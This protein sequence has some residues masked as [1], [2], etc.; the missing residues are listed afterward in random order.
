MGA[1]IIPIKVFAYSGFKGEEKPAYFTVKGDKVKVEE[2]LSEWLE[3]K[4]DE[5]GKRRHYFQ[6]K[7]KNGKRW[8]IF[9]SFNLE[10]WFLERKA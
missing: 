4:I 9:Y 7:D 1:I 2:I 8:K 6:V 10:K 3:E 5:E